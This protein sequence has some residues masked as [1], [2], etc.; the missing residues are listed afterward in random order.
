M[1]DTFFIFAFALFLV[2]KGATLATKYASRLASDLNLSK[3][4]VGFIVIAVISV[5]P[6]AFIAITAAVNGVPTLGLGTLIGTSFAD[7]TLILGL[8][9]VIAGRGM[10]IEN[11]II[12]RNRGYPFLILLPLILGWDGQ[13]TRVEG[14]VLFIAGAV[15]YFLAFSSEKNIRYKVSFA[16][17][18][19]KALTVFLLLAAM[20]VLLLGSHFAV[21]A[22]SALASGLGVKPILIGLLVLGL[23]TTMPELFFAIKSMKHK[24]D[25][26]AM[27][28]ILGTVLVNVTVV[29]GVVIM[30]AP[31]SFEPSAMYIAGVFLI[32]ASFIL[33]S[34]MKSGRVLSR[35]EGQLLLVFWAFYVLVEL[36]F[37]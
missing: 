21:V 32:A 2:I 11:R 19:E 8:V 12:S 31:F 36:I 30:I 9:T 34:F 13:Y 17:V 1:I 5:L 37:G 33:F 20:G 6:E 3:Y 35:F 15:F 26:L 16:L 14:A 25:S 24:E 22:G 18:K 29:L 10:K 28:D 23:G 4:T 7:I 27:G